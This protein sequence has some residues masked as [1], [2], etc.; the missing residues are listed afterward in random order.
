MTKGVKFLCYNEKITWAEVVMHGRLFEMVYILLNRKSVTAGE[1]AERFGISQRTVYRDIDV[2][3]LAGIPVCTE[4][5]KGG[6]ISLLPEFVLNRSVLSEK[7]QNEILS[8]LQS[9]SVVKAADTE[10]VLQKLS[11][12]F[13]KSTANWLEIDFSGWS[14]SDG[15]LFHDLKT[16]ILERRIVAFDYY[17]T[18]GEKTRR[19]VEPIQLWFKARA[20]YVK[21]FCLTK[22]DIRLFKLSR[23]RD[24]TVSDERFD[25]TRDLTAPPQ[26]AEPERPHKR[27]ITLK[28]KIAPEMTYRI[29]DEFDCAEA[30]KQEDGSHIVTVVWPEDEWVYGSILSYGEYAEVLSP[31]H[32]RDIIKEKAKKIAKKYS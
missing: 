10:K 7:E 18:Y 3:T 28:L 29:Y 5:G 8:A 32:I 22:R 9:L 25:G 31:P 16:A 6:G 20:W 11:A 17:S 13:N 15:Q 24:W 19:Q 12:V 21:G 2:L 26:G 27:D 1:L 23:I 14:Y 4:K 30:E